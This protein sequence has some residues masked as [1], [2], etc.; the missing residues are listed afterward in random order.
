MGKKIKDLEKF[1][2]PSSA[3][4]KPAMEKVKPNAP[5]IINY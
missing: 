5:N 4:Y 2:T 1:N 3:S